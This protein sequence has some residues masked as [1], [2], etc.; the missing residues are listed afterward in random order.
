MTKQEVD[1]YRTLAGTLTEAMRFTP[2]TSAGQTLQEMIREHLKTTE[3]T[4]FVAL[5]D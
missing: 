2:T 5:H 1:F 4:I 3:F